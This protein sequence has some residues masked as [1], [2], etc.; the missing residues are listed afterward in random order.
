[1]LLAVAAA[2]IRA[3]VRGDRR[4]R[5]DGAAYPAAVR[6]VCAGFVALTAAG[7]FRG[8]VGTTRARRPLVSEVARS[9]WLAAFGDPRFARL[10]AAEY[11]GPAIE[12]SVLGPLD[13]L[14][15]ASE[16]AV[17]AVLRPGID[18]LILGEGERRATYLTQVWE[19]G[20]TAL[21]F[22]RDLKHKAGI[23]P[24]YWSAAMSAERYQVERFSAAVSAIRLGADG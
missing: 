23:A 11:R 8:C 20:M 1:M 4:P 13:P 15:T 22:V 5:L 24:D 2:S 18:G 12:V 10:T 7:Q 16:A 3:G 17:V 9:A 14:G 6:K 19:H 21:D